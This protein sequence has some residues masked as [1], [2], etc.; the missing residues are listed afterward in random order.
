[1]IYQKIIRTVMIQVTLTITL[2]QSM[3]AQ[4][5]VSADFFAAQPN[6]VFS[7]ALAIA[8]IIVIEQFEEMLF[9]FK[10]MSC[11]RLYHCWAH[12]VHSITITQ[13]PGYRTTN[14]NER[15]E[16]PYY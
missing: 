14:S 11:I 10:F 13:F 3:A 6:H 7:A 5:V 15:V 4:A 2:S 12:H 9:D 8:H 16:V 1:M